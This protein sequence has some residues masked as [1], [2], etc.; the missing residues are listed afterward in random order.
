LR[1]PSDLPDAVA[2]PPRETGLR[3]FRD[4]RPPQCSIG[5]ARVVLNDEPVRLGRAWHALLERAATVDA[6]A[7]I[8]RES[9]ARRFAIDEA[10]VARVFDAAQAVLAAPHLVRFFASGDAELELLDAGGELLRIDRLVSIED[11]WWVVDFKWRV[12]TEERAA[13]TRQVRRYCEI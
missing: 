13:Y 10:Q 7:K 11:T 6:L 2:E 3:Q 1:V 5:T 8:D 12:T 4:F 9:L